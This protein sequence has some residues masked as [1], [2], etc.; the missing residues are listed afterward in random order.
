[1][2]FCFHFMDFR[3]YRNLP[4]FI[5]CPRQH[6]D[7]EVLSFSTVLPRENNNKYL[8]FKI[9]QAQTDELPSTSIKQFLSKHFIHTRGKLYK[10][11]YGI[12]NLGV[13]AF[14][15]ITS[16]A[17]VALVTRCHGIV[18]PTS[19]KLIKSQIN[20]DRKIIR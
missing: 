2:V 1:M 16:Y 6:I 5:L 19:S 9:R 12:K 11:A 13:M 4:I 8:T 10:F 20:S 18:L 3:M 17:I 14:I 7:L 15:V